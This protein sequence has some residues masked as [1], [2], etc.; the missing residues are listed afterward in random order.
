MNRIN[1]IGIAVAAVIL[2]LALTA[3]GIGA[4]DVMLPFFAVA[5]AL[6]FVIDLISYR[7]D[8]VAG[9][10]RAALVFRLIMLAVMTLILAAA[11]VLK[12]VF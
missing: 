8:K 10:P 3:K 4:S 11:S 2:I 9:A 6:L 5:M 12:F 7:K 1:L